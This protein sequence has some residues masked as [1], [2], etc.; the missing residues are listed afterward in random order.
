M[1]S[2]VVLTKNE[3]RDLQSCLE[4]ASPL[5]DLHVVDSGSEDSTV[6]IA[7]KAGAKV[8]IH[9]F[10]SFGR[11]RNFS[12]D[13]CEIESEWVLF[14][15]ADELATPEFREA[16]L[17]ATREAGGDIAGFYCCW[18][19]MLDDRWLKRCDSF[20]KW[21]FRLLRMGKARFTDFGHGQKEG[22]VEGH[23]GYL[24]EPYLHFGFSKGWSHWLA[25]HNRYSS[26]EA[27]ARLDSKRPWQEIF[28]RH[29]STRNPALKSV[30]SRL[31]GW[32]LIRFFYPYLLKF[33]FLEGRQGFI[34]C[35][36]LAYYEFLIQI[37]MSELKHQTSNKVD[38]I[39]PL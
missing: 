12:L 37:K 7:N 23:I 2:V 28:S 14:L 16:A 36:N 10:Q 9:P 30:L 19:M 35:V 15:D 39:S 18:K 13:H 8:L 24:K 1:I 29:P 33:G 11:Q 4:A 25:R 38:M 22:Q 34:Y 3:E 5:G 31:P 32:P 17:A 20:P 21:Q 6:A 27:R 26:Q